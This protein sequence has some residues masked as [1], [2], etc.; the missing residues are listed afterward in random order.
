MITDQAKLTQETWTT[1]V[2]WVSVGAKTSLFCLDTSVE[3]TDC[4]SAD[5]SAA[6]LSEFTDHFDVVLHFERCSQTQL[7]PSSPSPTNTACVGAVQSGKLPAAT[8]NL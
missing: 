3:V 5:P 7:C 2:A 4:P 8:G 1:R 6:A